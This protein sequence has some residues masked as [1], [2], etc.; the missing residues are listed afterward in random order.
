MISRLVLALVV[1]IVV[2]LGCTFLLGPILASLPV[3]IAGFVGGFLETW[4]WTLG[5]LAGLWKFFSGKIL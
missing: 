5:V 4:G 1:A 2:G 3:P